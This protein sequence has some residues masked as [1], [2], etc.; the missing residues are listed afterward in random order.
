[1]NTTQIVE[2]I[3]EW[4]LKIIKNGVSELN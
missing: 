1:M 4:G 2:I 3:G